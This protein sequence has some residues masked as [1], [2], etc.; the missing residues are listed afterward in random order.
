MVRLSSAYLVS[1][2]PSIVSEQ[3]ARQGAYA[4]LDVSLSIGSADR[5]WLLSLIG[6]NLTDAFVATSSVGLPLSGGVSGCR[7]SACGPQLA[8]DQAV[9]VENPRTVALQLTVSF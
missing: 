2:F 4:M 3:I 8:A 5:R 1:P 6:R 7:V 9:T